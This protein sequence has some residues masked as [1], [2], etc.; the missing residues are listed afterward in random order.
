ME[1]FTVQSK[2]LDMDTTPLYS[3]Q[4][5]LWWLIVCDGGAGES[6]SILRVARVRCNQ[7]GF[8][9]SSIEGGAAVPP[10][11]RT[12]RCCFCRFEHVFPRPFYLPV[13]SEQVLM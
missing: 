4:C 3:R 1:V 11:Y 10:R 9:V 7:G 13:R 5:V 8:F 6:G 2:L 12:V